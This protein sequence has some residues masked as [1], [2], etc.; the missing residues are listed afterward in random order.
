MGLECVFQQEQQWQQHQQ[1]FSSINFINLINHGGEVTA[2]RQLNV[3]V[4][5]WFSRGWETFPSGAKRAEHPCGPGGMN[6]PNNVQF[7]VI[8]E[9]C[10][11]IITP[12]SS[13]INFNWGIY[14]PR[15]RKPDMNYRTDAS[16]CYRFHE[17]F[18]DSLG[19]FLYHKIISSILGS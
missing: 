16:H 9:L 18:R 17:D 10:T 1:L 8:T 4:N 2:D 15:I 6:V 14:K 19:I 12:L 13:T 11:C 3:A 5:T 7:K